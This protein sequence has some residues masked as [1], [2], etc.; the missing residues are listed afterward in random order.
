[1]AVNRAKFLG[2]DRVLDYLWSAYD[3][4]VKNEKNALFCVFAI[5]GFRMARLLS[6]QLAR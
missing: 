3:I 6:L 1:M 2:R 5:N 4:F